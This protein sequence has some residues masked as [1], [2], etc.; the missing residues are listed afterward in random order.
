MVVDIIFPPM[1]IL[2]DF[3]VVKFT[4]LSGFFIHYLPFE[5]MQ[6]NVIYNMISAGEV[7]IN[8]LFFNTGNWDGGTLLHQ[9]PFIEVHLAL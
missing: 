5:I 4:L 8:L 3:H 9:R 2:Y 1:Q 7:H 6:K